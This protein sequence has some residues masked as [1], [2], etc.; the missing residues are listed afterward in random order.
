[1]KF[2]RKPQSSNNNKYY[3]EEHFINTIDMRRKIYDLF[4]S[5]KNQVTQWDSC[6]IPSCDD[7]YYWLCYYYRDKNSGDMNTKWL[8]N[9]YSAYLSWPN[10]PPQ[11]LETKNNDLWLFL[12]VLWQMGLCMLG[13]ASG[14]WQLHPG[15]SWVYNHLR[16]H[17][18][19]HLRWWLTPMPESW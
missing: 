19:E 1:M 5:E 17:G 7:H 14:L 15:I 8:T 2:Y 6:I 10:K 18:V 16:L 3:P 12:S 11:D 13:L 4:L 9:I